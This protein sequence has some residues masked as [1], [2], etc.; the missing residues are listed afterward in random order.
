MDSNF[1]EFKLIQKYV[2]GNAD[3]EDRRLIKYWMDLHPDNRK[4]VQEIEEIWNLTPNENFEVDVQLAWEQFQKCHFNEEQLKTSRTNTFKHTLSKDNRKPLYIVRAAA[5]L[6][7]TLIGGL[8]VEN[9]LSSQS[10]IVQA[11]DFYKMETIETGKSEKARVTF[12]DGTRVLL[13]SASSLRFPNEFH[14]SSREVYL[15]G[16]AYFEVAHD[17]NHPFI[18]YSQDAE[19]QVLGT[20]FNVRGWSDDPDVEI[21][22]REGKVAV[23]SSNQLTEDPSRVIL[24]AGFFTSV[25]KGE[26]PAFAKRINVKDQLIW[27][28]GGLHFDNVPFKQVIRDIERRFNVEVTLNEPLADLIEDVPFTSTFYNA[29]VDEVLNVIAEA[30]EIEYR[31]EDTKI[32]FYN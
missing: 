17:H 16:E 6:L 24:N 2:T 21:S 19:V 18:V 30:M 14:G 7:V 23:S 8:L 9:Y 10:E 22:V 28:N 25:K 4:L 26:E 1:K 3:P 31:Q 5:I 13:N 15:E 29:D 12:S 32:E 27:I 20:E 11:S